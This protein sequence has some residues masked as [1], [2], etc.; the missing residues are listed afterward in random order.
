MATSTLP[1]TRVPQLNRLQVFGIAAAV[2]G[3]ALLA[4]GFFMSPLLF[5]ESYIFG[6]YFTM[7]FPLGCLGF[8]M[9]QHLTGGVWGIT[10]RRML[11]A[12]ALA[13][14]IFFILSLPVIMFVY[15]SP[16]TLEHFIYHWADPAVVT[17][18]SPEFDPIVAH[19]VPWMS[20]LWF[21][22]RMVI[23]FLIWSV[24]P[25]LLRTWSLQQDRGADPVA[26][27]TRMR[28]L[29]GIGIALFVLSTT[30]FALDVGMSLDAHW[31][32]TMYGAHYI[33]NSGLSV[34]AFLL[35][36]MTQLRPSPVFEEHVPTKAVHDLGKLLFAF[37]V[38]WTYISF[39]QFVIIWSGDVAEFTPWYIR[40][41]NGGWVFFS[42]VLMAFAF[43]GPF[44][45]L[46]GRRP[47]RNLQYV[48]AVAGWILF[49]RVVDMA[50]VILPEF[51]DTIAEISWVNLVAPLG[52]F[53]IWLS[54]WA[55]NMQQAPLL[56]MNDPNFDSLHAGGHH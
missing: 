9:V 47:K 22:I 6:F 50:W 2:I 53:G 29:S 37:T 12:G 11:E 54:I 28:K 32:S 17:P 27:A 56:P 48:A 39:G 5:A 23:Y 8:L 44:L 25:I 40:R 36:A 3:L 38:L 4:L 31:Y 19:K 26:S 35:L 24:L 7:A 55:W 30:F 18:G 45:A 14:P 42:L 15:N 41:Q 34:L 21:T 20:P 49:F 52:I 51:H 1:R 10:V 46:L 16:L 13:M 33:V 43:A